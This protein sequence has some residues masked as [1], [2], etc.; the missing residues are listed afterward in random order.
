[1]MPK[2]GRFEVSEGYNGYANR[3]TW[4][5]VL[6]LMNDESVY[7]N[8]QSQLAASI[9]F[10][11]VADLDGYEA[12]SLVRFVLGTETPDGVSTD[13]PAIDWDQV[14]SVFN[15]RMAELRMARAI[16]DQI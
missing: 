1:M 13:D 10:G 8:W 15:E 5:V 3:A 2:K 4:N 7:N 12:G 16:C 9:K 6:W 11:M 14:A